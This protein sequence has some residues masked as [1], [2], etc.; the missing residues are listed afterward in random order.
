MQ[1]VFLN[2]IEKI[3]RRIDK[4][5]VKVDEGWYSVGEMRNELKWPPCLF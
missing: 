3:V 2:K 1:D 5:V 4:H